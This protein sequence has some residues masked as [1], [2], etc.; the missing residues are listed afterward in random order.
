MGGAIV[1]SKYSFIFKMNV[2]S[3]YINIESLNEFKFYACCSL[4]DAGIFDILILS[5]TWFTKSFN[6]M[7]HP[8]S[9]VQST[10]VKQPTNSHP[11]GGLLVLASNAV[12]SLVKPIKVTQHG[13]LIDVGGIRI[14]SVYLPPSLRYDEISQHLSEFSSYHILQ[15]DINVRF[16]HIS[17]AKRLSSP[18]LQSFWQV[19]LAEHSF[20]SFKVNNDPLKV[21]SKHL[22]T[23]S[24]SHSFLLNRRFTLQDGDLYT[25]LPNY[26]LDHAFSSTIVPASVDLLGSQQFN[27]RTVH[28][29]FLR[30]SFGIDSWT[31]SE[32]RQGLGRYHLEFLEKRGIPEYLCHTWDE[33]EA[34]VNWN[35][36]QDVDVY[37]S[38]L[39]NSIQSVAE[40]ILGSY[41]VLVKRKSPDKSQSF[42]HTQLSAVAAIQLFKR[43]QRGANPNLTIQSENSTKSAMDECIDKFSSLFRTSDPES[44][45]DIEYD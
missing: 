34:E 12:R 8:Y 38:V 41:D 28:K 33:L 40:V 7:A 6:Y 24:S 10:Y 3:G 19:W 9:I 29:Y 35:D 20:S 26:E 14:L 16:K 23:F 32:E 39:T 21:T 37:D 18:E 42:L 44:T 17:T 30:L 15:G 1:A 22:Q 25:M 11:I 5:E 13:I 2:V 31:A 27:L 43:K 4:I 36:I 45:T